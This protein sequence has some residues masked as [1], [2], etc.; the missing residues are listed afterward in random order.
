MNLYFRNIVFVCIA[1]AFVFAGLL[2]YSLSAGPKMEWDSKLVVNEFYVRSQARD[3]GAAHRLL[4]RSLQSRLSI[5]SL[6]QQWSAF[7]QADGPI[8]NW[9]KSAGMISMG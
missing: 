7:E 4:S 2:K 8:K 1:C 5:Q 3:Y 6:S 9:S